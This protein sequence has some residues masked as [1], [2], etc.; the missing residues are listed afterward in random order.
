MT[1][2][3]E[4]KKGGRINT[5]LSKHP[6][7]S[8]STNA[9]THK[10]KQ[11]KSKKRKHGLKRDGC[12]YV[13]ERPIMCMREEMRDGDVQSGCIERDEDKRKMP[14]CHGRA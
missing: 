9:Q 13:G 8:M 6:Q 12:M 2:V 3:V 1:D 7:Q 11:T 14:Q 5:F 4:K 10:S